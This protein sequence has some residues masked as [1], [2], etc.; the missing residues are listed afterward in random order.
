M[1]NTSARRY[2]LQHPNWIV[3][4]MEVRW[5]GIELNQNLMQIHPCGI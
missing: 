3:T 1:K 2:I 4:K 5:E